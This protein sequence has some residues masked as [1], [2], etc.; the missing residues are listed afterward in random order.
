MIKI[1][2]ILVFKGYL[3]F[4]EPKISGLGMQYV[5]RVK[6]KVQG[7]VS[8]LAN[9]GNGARWLPLFCG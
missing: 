1:T 2:H 9:G 3:F 4:I 7:S 6:E 8:A 5:C